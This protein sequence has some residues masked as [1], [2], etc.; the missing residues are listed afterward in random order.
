MRVAAFALAALLL[1]GCSSPSPGPDAGEPASFDLRDVRV[2]WR[3]DGVEGA[4]ELTWD[5]VAASWADGVGTLETTTEGVEGGDFR[6]TLRFRSG[7]PAERLTHDANLSAEGTFAFDYWEAV[8]WASRPVTRVES[9]DASSWVRLDELDTRGGRLAGAFHLDFVGRCGPDARQCV[10]GDD[11]PRRT[12]LD[13]R[14]G[15]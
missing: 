15:D 6:F 12:V 11:A 9:V 5:V 4:R 3:G 2:A 13:G 14:F 1:A 7:G 8:F 10:V